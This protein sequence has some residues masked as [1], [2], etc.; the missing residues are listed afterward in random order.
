MRDKKVYG[1]TK[2]L[3]GRHEIK[4]YLRIFVKFLVEFGDSLLSKLPKQGD[5]FNR[6][7]SESTLAV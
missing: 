1:R 6:Q 3:P 2:K 4:S 5:S 7:L